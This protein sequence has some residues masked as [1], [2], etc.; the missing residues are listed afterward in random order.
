M[1]WCRFDVEIEEAHS[2]TGEIIND[3]SGRSAEDAAA[4]DAKLAVAQI[5]YEHY[6]NVRLIR[7]LSKARRGCRQC[8]RSD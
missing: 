5:I 2:L 7:Q 4:V 3:R 6:D 1:G 8:E